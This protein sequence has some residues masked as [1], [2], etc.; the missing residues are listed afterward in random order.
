MLKTQFTKF[1]IVGC[2]N[3][4]FG[5][6][7]Y[8]LFVLLGIH[9]AIA[10]FLST[11]A[12]VIFNFK[13]TGIFVFKNRDN[14]LLLR[15]IGVYLIIYLI[16]VSCLKLF[17]LMKMNMLWSGALLILPMAAVSFILNKNFVFIVVA[18]ARNDENHRE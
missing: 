5:Y 4:L 18:T 11:V 1:L 6:S 12:G 15:F 2:V 17:A 13:S 9:Y 14:T 7:V 8:A 16:S 3:T 10:S